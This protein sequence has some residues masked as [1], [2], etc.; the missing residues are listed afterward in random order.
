MWLSPVSLLNLL[1][2]RTPLDR[3]ERRIFQCK[4]GRL[5]EFGAV[6]ECGAA[7]S[8]EAESEGPFKGLNMRKKRALM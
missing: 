2:H 8:N 7:G 3:S 6:K 4:R 1:P 5:G